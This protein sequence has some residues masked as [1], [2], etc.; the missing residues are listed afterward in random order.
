VSPEFPFVPVFRLTVSVRVPATA[1]MGLYPAT[2]RVSAKVQQRFPVEA[3]DV[4]STGC[5]A[6]DTGPVPPVTCTVWVFRVGAP[7]QAADVS[8]ALVAAIRPSRMTFTTPVWP[9][10]RPVTVA[11]SDNVVFVGD[12]GGATAV[13]SVVLVVMVGANTVDSAAVPRVVDT[14]VIAA[15]VAVEL[16]VSVHAVVQPEA[17]VIVVATSGCISFYSGHCSPCYPR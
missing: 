9:G 1:L 10:A 2:L 14:G 5:E 11:M 12:P 6:T 4:M 7:F 13:F 8:Q 15:G 3:R 17:S 16:R